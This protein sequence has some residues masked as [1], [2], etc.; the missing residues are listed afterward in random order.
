MVRQLWYTAHY[1]IEWIIPFK[2]HYANFSNII[3][4]I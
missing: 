2:K 3:Y 4:E 1:E